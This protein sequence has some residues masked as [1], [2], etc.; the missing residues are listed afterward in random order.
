MAAPYIDPQVKCMCVCVGGVWC[1]GWG[2]QADVDRNSP[3]TTFNR[4][5]NAEDRM[6]NLRLVQYGRVVGSDILA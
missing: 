6:R 4:K 5:L 3:A 2:V 1:G